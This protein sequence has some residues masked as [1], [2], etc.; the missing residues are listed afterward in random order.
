[1]STT[2]VET[3]RCS[4][5]GVFDWP[6]DG[7]GISENQASGIRPGSGRSDRVARA[8]GSDG[9]EAPGQDGLLRM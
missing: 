1:M 3:P 6:V 8:A 2:Y 5:H 4:H 7:T 9:A